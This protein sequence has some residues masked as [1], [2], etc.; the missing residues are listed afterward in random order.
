MTS[1]L[2]TFNKLSPQLAKNNKHI[3]TQFHVFTKLWTHWHL[4]KHTLQN[5]KHICTCLNTFTLTLNT[6]ALAKTHVAQKYEQFSFTKHILLTWC[7]MVDSVS[8]SWTQ[9]KHRCHCL[10]THD[11]KLKTPANFVTTSIL[12]SLE[13]HYHCLNTMTQNWRHVQM[14]STPI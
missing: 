3:S 6:F 2:N 8:K 4:L 1:C 10:N 11:A 13:S 9:W 14:M 5:S 12:A 7:K